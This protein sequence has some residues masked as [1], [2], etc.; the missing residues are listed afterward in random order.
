MSRIRPL[1]ANKQASHPYSPKY[2]E[3]LSEKGFERR[4]DYEF[5]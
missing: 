1:K 5:G 4:S 2:L 3:K